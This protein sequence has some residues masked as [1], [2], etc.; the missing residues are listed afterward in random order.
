MTASILSAVGR[1][2]LVELPNLFANSRGIRVLA[3]LELLNPGGSAKDRPAL[4][5]IREAW[6][7]GRIVPGS[8]IVESSSGNTAISLAVVC[9]QLK[10][11]FICVVDPRTAQANLDILRAFGAEIDRVE[12]PDPATGEFL[13]ARLNRVQELLSE[14]PGSFW[15]NQ[16]GN[17]N[18]W[19]SQSETMKEIV[20]EAG[21][22]DYVF[23]GV[24][25]CGT[26]LG[27]AAYAR[28]RG[29]SARIVAV[30]SETSAI[31]G[32]AHG[33]RRF[34]GMG[35]GI[36]PPFGQNRFW[37]EAVC[38]S[39]WDMVAGCRALALREG[40]LAGPSSGGVMEAV[41]R[42]LPRL[43]D[44]AVCAVILHDRG[45]RYLDTVYSDEWVI[46]Q[47]GRTPAVAATEEDS[48]AY[49]ERY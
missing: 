2:P 24:S 20:E 10:L 4:R 45:E 34:P 42:M 35:A 39:D 21:R 47:F 11:K 38:V 19:R 13:P 16:Y 3:K 25:T 44:R 31:L 5:M 36:V 23:G 33:K 40:I 18:N 32:G 1:T 9:A 49:L 43:P 48:G 29:L 27:C 17:E 26:M 14:L 6:S 41:R 22:V 30:D 7:T 12:Q 46:R 28:E 8:V 15:P 37:D